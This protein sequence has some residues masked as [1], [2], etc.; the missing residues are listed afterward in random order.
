MSKIP[1]QLKLLLDKPRD[2]TP[3]EQKEWINTEGKKWADLQG[4]II[5][6]L[7]ILQVCLLGFML[8]MMGII[9]VTVNG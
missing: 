7:S 9:E 8:G 5:I 2:A 6:G 1:Q 4:K 3:E